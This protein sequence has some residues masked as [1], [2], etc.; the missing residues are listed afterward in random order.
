METRKRSSATSVRRDYW[1]L[2][3][4]LAAD[5]EPE[6]LTIAGRRRTTEAFWP[7]LELPAS[8]I[9]RMLAAVGHAAALADSDRWPGLRTAFAVFPAHEVMAICRGPYYVIE[10]A[11]TTCSDRPSVQVTFLQTR[12][13]IRPA[14]LL[15]DDELGDFSADLEEIAAFAALDPTASAPVY[16]IHRSEHITNGEHLRA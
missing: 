13:A 12:G 6:L 4:K 16:Q 10:L 1:R 14:L 11:E 9:N 2:E 8:E 5:G 3:L 15:I 7:P